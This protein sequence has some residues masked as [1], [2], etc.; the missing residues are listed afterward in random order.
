MAIG[1]KPP[2]GAGGGGGAGDITKGANVNLDGVGVYE[3]KSGTI[4]QFRGVKSEHDN[5]ALTAVLDATNKTVDLDLEEEKLLFDSLDLVPSAAPAYS[6][7]RQWLDSTREFPSIWS[8]FTDVSYELGSAL[9]EKAT[10]QTGVTIPAGTP[11]YYAGRNGTTVLMAPADAADETKSKLFVGVTANEA[12]N[13]DEALVRVFGVLPDIDTNTWDEGTILYIAEGGGL[14]SARPGSPNYEVVVGTVIV[15]DAVAG[16]LGINI[17]IES[18]LHTAADFFVG[19][20]LTK[21]GVV[22]SSDGVDITA[23][24]DADGG[25]DI[26]IFKDDGKLATIPTTPAVSVTLTAGSDISP[27]TNYVYIDHADDTIKPSTSAPTGQYALLWFGD[28]QTAATVQLYGPVT[29]QRTSNEMHDDVNNGDVIHISNRL[30]Q[31]SAVYESGIQ[32]TFAVDTVTSPDSITIA[33]TAGAAWQKHLQTFAAVSDPAPFYVWNDPDAA[34]T[35]RTNIN[36]IL[37]DS[38]GTIW[39]SP[40]SYFTLYWFAVVSSPDSDFGKI[41]CTLPSGDY[42]SLDAAISDASKYANRSAPAITKGKAVPL[43]ETVIQVTASGEAWT[44]ERTV[45]LR[46]NRQG[47]VAGGGAINAIVDFPDNA[48][49]IFDFND[50]TAV[51][52]FSAQNIPTATEVETTFAPFDV[53]LAQVDSAPPT[54]VAAAT[55]TVLTTHVTLEVDYTATGA[56]T[57][58]IDSDNAVAGRRFYIVDTGGNAGTNNITINTEGAETINGEVSGIIAADYESWEVYSDGTNF[59]IK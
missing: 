20:T 19:S 1:N 9:T 23:A 10:N 29:S 56:V 49:S 51:A 26:V 33:N 18:N 45:D 6:A 55:F 13:G 2:A 11:V 12:L 47:S 27:Q 42:A 58:T 34:Y 24:I 54:T 31:E 38:T 37:K 57:I 16:V 52:T 44:V 30:R 36:A 4:L 21:N 32:M 7:G 59:F 15:K 3:G 43:Y 8:K 35:R 50:D 40:K 17:N 48:F 25:G 22:I 46:G 14:T 28:V 53:D 39:T 5:A 41:Y